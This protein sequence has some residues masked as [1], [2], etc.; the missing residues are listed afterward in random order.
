MQFPAHSLIGLAA[1]IPVTPPTTSLTFSPVVLNVPSR[2]IP[3]LQLRVSFPPTGS[4][5]PIVLLSHGLG[6]SNSLSSLE[7]YAP[8]YDFLSGHGFVV[9]QPTHLNS[10]FYGLTDFPTGNE[11]Y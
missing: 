11:F 3:D 5:L 1:N 4:D 10:R 9:I 8:I 6:Q 7:G 2:P